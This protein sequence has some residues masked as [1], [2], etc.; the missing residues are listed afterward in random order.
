ML[1]SC[2]CGCG[3]L[4]EEF[5]SQKRKRKFK[6]G[7]WWGGKHRTDKTKKKLSISI[8]KLWEDEKYYNMM[9]K[10]HKGKFF[11]ESSNWKGGITSL[12]NQIRHCEQYINWRI[13][14]FGRDNFTCQKCGKRGVWLEAHHKKPFHQILKNNNITTFESA[15]LCPELWDLNNGITHCK[16]CHKQINK[17]R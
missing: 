15:I 7:H 12:N 1:I 16:D 6:H 9:S 13:Q 11:E 5:D 3:T 8:K 14:I 4:I 17:R 10:S 2:T